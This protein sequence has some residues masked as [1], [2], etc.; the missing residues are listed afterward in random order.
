MM[1]LR[2]LIAA[3]VCLLTAG[4]SAVPLRVACVG[5][6]ITEGSGLGNSATES[7]PAKLQRLLGSVYQV[8][9]FGVSGRTL[10]KKGDYPYWKESA[11]T[12]SHTSNPDI[13]LI[14]LGTN[15]SKSWNWRYSTNFVSDYLEL[16]ATYTNLSSH[17]RIML[18]TPC[19]VFGSGV[20]S[21]SPGIVRTNIAPAVRDLGAQLGLEVLDLQV[22]LAGHQEWFPDT[23]HPNS[24]GTTVMAALIRSALLGGPP[25]GSPPPLD[26]ALAVNNRAVL[27]WPTDWA[28]LVL[29]STTAIR[30][31]NT[32]WTVVEQVAFN[33]GA[34][35]RVTN[36]I[37]G[38][39]RLYRLWQP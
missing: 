14:M 32:L 29:Q 33:D 9:N 36:P 2:P 25:T 1:P 4:V 17:P 12:S 11:Y 3:L 28:G 18:S 20:Y 21:I 19:P 34:A 27:E 6:S 8:S 15:D 7:Y 13:V 5:D 10:L 31:T 30:A 23:V 38:I 16:I 24:K 37:S 22:L 35:V 26:L 39:L